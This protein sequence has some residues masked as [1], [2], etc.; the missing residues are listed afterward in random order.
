M[1][2]VDLNDIVKDL[3]SY[4]CLPFFFSNSQ[5]RL[6]LLHFCLPFPKHEPKS[7]N[8]CLLTTLQQRR[9]NVGADFSQFNSRCINI[10]L[11]NLR[12]KY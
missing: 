3:K 4:C 7:C 12:A 10:F 2:D 5:K 11:F 6:F 9:E 8:Q 1:K